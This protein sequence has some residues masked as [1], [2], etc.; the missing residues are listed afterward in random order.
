ATDSDLGAVTGI[1]AQYRFQLRL[2]EQIGLGMP[3]AARVGV[4]IE[5]RQYMTPGSVDQAQPERGPGD[6]IECGA[7]P[8][9]GQYPADLTVEMHRAGLRID[10]VPALQDN[11]FDTVLREQG[12]GRQPAGPRADDHDRNCGSAHLSARLARW[13]AGC[14]GRWLCRRCRSILR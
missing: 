3:V 8:Q 13:C 9:P 7:H 2:I 5:L 12:R 6:G 10:A 14:R 1:F 11:R 4:T